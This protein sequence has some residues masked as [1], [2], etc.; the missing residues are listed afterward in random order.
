MPHPTDISLHSLNEQIQASN[1]DL[2][3][4]R[5][6]ASYEPFYQSIEDLPPVYKSLATYVNTA[7]DRDQVSDDY[8][9]TINPSTMHNSSTSDGSEGY[10]DTLNPDVVACSDPSSGSERYDDSI[11]PDSMNLTSVS[12]T[13]CAN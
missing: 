7:S 11:N 1:V 2:P 9:D 6:E 4:P 12:E 8:D 13:G 10:D 3:A 5:L